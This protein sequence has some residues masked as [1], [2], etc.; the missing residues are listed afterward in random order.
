MTCV[1][2]LMVV[3]LGT[4]ALGYVMGRDTGYEYGY[5]QAEK[6]FKNHKTTNKEN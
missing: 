4:L 5:N 1:L 6:Y 3:A 2:F